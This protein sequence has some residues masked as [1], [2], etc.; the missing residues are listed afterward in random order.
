MSDPLP[1]RTT[2]G[3]LVYASRPAIDFE[4]LTADLDTALAGCDAGQVSVALEREGLAL[5]DVGASRVGIALAAGLDRSGAAAVVVTVGHGPASQGEA[6]LARRQSMLARLI[7]QRIA[8]SFPP[9]E[10]LWSETGEVVTPGMFDRIH[11]EL[12]ERRRVQGEMQ[13]DQARRTLPRHAVEPADLSRM[14]ARFEATL[15]ARR[16]GFAEAAAPLREETGREPDERR[17]TPLL[18]FAAHLIDATLMLVALP[19]GAAMMIYSLSRGPD[20]HA[21]ARAMAISGLGLGL[22][23][24]MGSTVALGLL[25]L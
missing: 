25:A 12:I 17:S 13:A 4:R 18:R 6:S 21:S 14:F 9:V 5:I 3:Q 8:A 1:T 2:I 16:A 23:Y 20:L 24:M 10:T 7:A 11:E 15:D 22:L 19:V